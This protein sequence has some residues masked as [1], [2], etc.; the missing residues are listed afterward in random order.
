LSVS[1]RRIRSLLLTVNCRSILLRLT[2]D[3]RRDLRLLTERRGRVLRRLTERRRSVLLS[4]NRTGALR[5]LLAVGRR[6][7]LRRLP[8]AGLAVLW[9]LAVRL[10]LSITWLA[11]R[12]LSLR[13]L[14]VLNGTGGPVRLLRRSGKRRPR[15]GVFLVRYGFGNR[16]DCQDHRNDYN[17]YQMSHGYA[18]PEEL[19]LWLSVSSP[20]ILPMPLL[21]AVSA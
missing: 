4:E 21:M 13:A 12:G 1:G 14:L 3:R 10:R 20:A 2:E 15:C 17:I 7:V 19:V 16:S 9:R 6:D 11:I 8:I 18:P 5:S